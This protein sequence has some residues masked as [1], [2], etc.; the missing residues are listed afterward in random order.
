MK[1]LRSPRVGRRVS[2][3]LA[4]LL[5]FVT[6]ASAHNSREE[7]GHHT[8]G[9]PVAEAHAAPPQ[10]AAFQRFSPSVQ[11]RWDDRFLYVASNGLPAH[12]MMTGITAWQQQVPLPQAYVGTNAWRIPLFPVPAAEPQ[13]IKGRFLRGAIALAANGIPIFNPQNNRGEISQEIGELD[14]WGGHCGRADDYHYHAAPLH[15]QSVVGKALPIA[16]ALDGYAIYGLSDPDGSAPADLDACRGHVTAALGYHYHAST[17]YPYIN[18]GFHGQVVEREGQ[19]DPQPRAQP[20]RPALPPLRGAVI[21][22][23]TASPD[24]KS[25]A[26]TYTVNGRPAAVHYTTTGNGA[27]DFQFV[28]ADGTRREETY[29]ARDRAAGGPAPKAAPTSAPVTPSVPVGPSA[30]VAPVAPI[31]PPSKAA[32]AAGGTFKL[33]SPEVIDGGVLP[34][35]Y[36]G[37]GSG[38]TLPLAWSGAPAGTQAYVL[39]MHHLDPAGVAKWYWTLYDIPAAVR[40]LPKNVSGIG[41]VGTGFRGKVGYEPPHSRGPGAKTYIFTLYALSSPL[42]LSQAPGEVN[43]S[44]LLDAMKGKVLAMAD[45]NVSYTRSGAGSKSDRAEGEGP[46]PKPPRAP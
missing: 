38:A 30:P 3:R 25:F 46:S 4:G 14:Q 17:H 36:T 33:T 44:V 2:V 23:F 41:K 7:A 6:A 20:I 21:T 43:R 13:M 26:L 18:G 29:S 39:I 31:A 15:L 34:S 37:D 12:G 45:L 19:V 32:N 28:G 40:S 10:A 22:G 27:W 35:D 8:H 11:V 9:E 24:A 1:T 16:Y 5:S 42:R